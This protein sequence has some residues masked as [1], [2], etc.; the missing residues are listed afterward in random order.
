[1]TAYRTRIKHTTESFIEALKETNPH[2]LD[3]SQVEFTGTKQR[4]KL[5]CLDCGFE[6][7]SIAKDVLE[8]QTGCNKCRI[9]KLKVQRVKPWS[10]VEAGFR[11]KHGNLY[12]YDD[13]TYISSM[14][15]MKMF[16]SKHGEFWQ[17]PNNHMYNN[18]CYKCG[19]DSCKKKR[20][21]SEEEFIT[22][23]NEIHNS[24]YKYVAGT[25]QSCNSKMDIICPKHGLFNQVAGDHLQG[26]GC[27]KCFSRISGPQE[28]LEKF[29][30][31]LGIK[32]VSEYRL[33]S[34]KYL[35]I[36]CPEL[37]L[38]FEHN[39]LKWHTEQYGKDWTYHLNKTLDA[40]AENIRLIHIYGDEWYFHKER[41]KGV[42]RTIVG[43]NP[44]KYNA[45]NLDVK[46][47]TW[48][49]ASELLDSVH[50]QGAGIAPEISIG[51]INTNGE[52]LSV[53]CFDSRNVENNATELIRF[54]SKGIVRGGFSKLL[55]NAIK[56]LNKDKII[57]FSDIRFS[58]GKIYQKNGFIQAGS[59]RPR[60]WYVDGQKRVHRRFYQKQYLA[61]KLKIYNPNLTESENCKNNGIYRLWDCG[62]TKWELEIKKPE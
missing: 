52:L 21:F 30:N 7:E 28:E 54:C 36:F 57:S 41:V 49:E 14:K 45:R 32:T 43:K 53:M 58:I 8:K 23:A 37:H 18:G 38:G 62:K 10:E 48:K 31:D 24:F 2:N 13:T 26:H 40:E 44:V 50:L 61:D 20:A 33:A 46:I 5:K 1:M 59:V 11:I 42:V 22:K 19:R 16:C 47:C 60:Y 9:N 4:I 55:S 25:Y 6:F 12:R 51:L 27:V 34:G 39:G 15:D 3:F 29:I 35:D 17:T 56:I